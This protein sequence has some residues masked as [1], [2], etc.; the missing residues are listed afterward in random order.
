MI[1]LVGYGIDRGLWWLQ[2]DLFP[3]RYGGRGLCKRLLRGL[4]QAFSG[5]AE[6]EAAP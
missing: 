4:R 3:H 5:G 2:C 1:P 6:A